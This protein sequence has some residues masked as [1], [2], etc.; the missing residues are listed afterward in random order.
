M[1]QPGSSF[2]PIVYLTALENGFTPSTVILDAPIVDRSGSRPAALEAGE[3]RARVFS[4]RPRC[5]SGLEK[6]RNLMTVRVA[7][8]IGMAKVAEMAETL[9]RHRQSAADAR[10]VDRRRR[11]HG[12]AL[13]TAYSMIVNGG[14]KVDAD[15]DR[16]RAGQPRLD[17]LPPRRAPCD[18]CAGMAYD[19]QP[20]PTLPDN[21][22]QVLDPA[23]RLSDGLDDAGRRPA[24]HRLRGRARSASRSP[25]RPAPPMTASD[26]WFV[27]FS[28]DLAAGFY[29]GY[30][31][32]RSLGDEGDRRRRSRRRSSATS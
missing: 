22:E 21:R 7:Q 18:G 13:V 8:T 20:P 25:A 15:L 5:G 30:D 27:G 4:A 2:K 28:P 31:Q 10:H 12:A 24:R 19:G 11:D 6:S 29:L 16:P 1:R 14:K 23:G 3:L 9:G 26:V 17:D 32:P